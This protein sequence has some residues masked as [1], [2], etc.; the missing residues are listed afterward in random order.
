[1]VCTSI[2]RDFLNS[3]SI[4]H[5]MGIIN[6]IIAMVSHG[7]S[8]AVFG[9][10]TRELGVFLFEGSLKIIERGKFWQ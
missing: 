10:N 3:S 7:E 5:E 6:K 9:L 8:L 4:Y 2:D 1:M